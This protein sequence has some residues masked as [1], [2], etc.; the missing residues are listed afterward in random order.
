M[1]RRMKNERQ[2]GY[3]CVCVFFSFPFCRLCPVQ[4]T[5]SSLIATRIRPTRLVWKL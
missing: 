2:D 5:Q 4:P 3:A 1:H